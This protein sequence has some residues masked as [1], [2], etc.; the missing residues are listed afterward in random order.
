[1][2]T[3]TPQTTQRLRQVLVNELLDTLFAEV[4]SELRD[5]CAEWCAASPRFAAFL[6][7]YR[8]KI[9]KKLRSV[10]DRA[11]SM[12]G[13]GQRDLRAEL[14]TAACLLSERTFTLAYETYAAAK[15][16]GPDFSLLYKSHTAFNVEVK[17]IRGHVQPGKWADVLCDKL[18]QLPPS[19]SNVLVIYGEPVGDGQDA[20]FKAGA[21]MAELRSAAERKDD[22]VFTRRGLQGARDYLRQLPKLSMVVLRIESDSGGA[23]PLASWLNPQARHPLSPDL[24]RALLRSLEAL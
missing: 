18:Q 5:C 24:R 6:E 15:T 12:D 23:A 19:V 17:R 14:L 1:M 21:A 8:E 20:P 11:G 7:M 4:A 9:R 16:R 22:A 13:E 3:Q 2:T 10:T